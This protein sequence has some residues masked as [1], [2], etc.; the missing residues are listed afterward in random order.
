MAFL[1]ESP[2]GSI[3]P[4]A[5]NTTFQPTCPSG[6]STHVIATFKPCCPTAIRNVAG[7]AFR[8]RCPSGSA[9]PRVVNTTW[10]PVSPTG[11]KP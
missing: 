5:I 10:Q 11:A 6:A 8:A 3:T 2:S 7:Q 9:T 1:P 4:R